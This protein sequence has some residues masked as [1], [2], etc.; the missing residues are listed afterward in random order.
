MSFAGYECA[1]TIL[2]KWGEWNR[3]GGRHA[4]GCKTNWSIVDTTPGGGRCE[5]G[6]DEA[7]AV[8]SALAE[9]EFHERR[10]LKRF[11]VHLAPDCDERFVVA[12]VRRFAFVY[13]TPKRRIA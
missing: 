10:L 6:D 11:Y 12:A 5:M 4:P 1:D 2:A 9:L 8:N 3:D 13:D 7:L